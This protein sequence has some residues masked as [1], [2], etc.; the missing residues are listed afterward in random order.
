MTV[1]SFSKPIPKSGAIF[2]ASGYIGGPMARYLRFHAPE[3][4]LP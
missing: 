4:R 1:P 3:I 2:G